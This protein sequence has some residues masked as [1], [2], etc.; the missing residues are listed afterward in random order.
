MIHRL[1]PPGASTYNSDVE[2]AHRLIEEDFYSYEIINSYDDFFNKA[3]KYFK[4]FNYKRHNTYKGASPIKIMKKSNQYLDY[5]I[6]NFKPI[7]LDNYSD[8]SQKYF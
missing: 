2:T 8:L 3:W 6:S 4:Y 5:R 1:L 7:V